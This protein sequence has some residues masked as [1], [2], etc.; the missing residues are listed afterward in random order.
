MRLDSQTF[1][2]SAYLLL[3]FRSAIVA[4]DSFGEEQVTA[5]PNRP[6]VANPADVTQKG[7]LEI[8]YGWARAFRSP[9]F[10]SLTAASGLIRFGLTEDL[11]LRLG[12]DN[13]LSQRSDDPEGR[14]SGVGD[15]SPGF[16]YRLVEQDGFWPT[17]GFSY[18]VKV[19]T[20]SRKKGLGSGRVDHNLL[21]LASKDLFGLESNFNYLLGWIGKGRRKGFDDFHLWALSLSRPLFGPLAISG[22]LYGGLRL[23]RGTPGFTSTDWAFSYALTSRVVFDV[24]VD[25]GLTSTARDITYFA[26]VTIALIDLYRLFG[27]SHK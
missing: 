5:T 23:N 8:E 3:L 25:I 9:E 16:K 12:M 6:G 17:L 26:G 7:V 20:A 4:Q 13:Y 1:I 21:F 10:N 24:G 14:R 15:T 18:D 2:F 11:E 19:P 27:L 22:E